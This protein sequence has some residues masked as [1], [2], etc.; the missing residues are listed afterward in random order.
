MSLKFCSCSPYFIFTVVTHKHTI[1][2]RGR[3]AVL[4]FLGYL[5]LYH[6]SGSAF[7]TMKEG[8]FLRICGDFFFSFQ[9]G[10]QCVVHSFGILL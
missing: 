5:V 10:N 2:C 7:K 1:L 9:A 6:R 3:Q 8:F 4:I